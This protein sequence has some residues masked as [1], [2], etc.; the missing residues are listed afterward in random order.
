MCD[1]KGKCERYSNNISIG[2]LNYKMGNSVGYNLIGV[3][4][5]AAVSLLSL[6]LLF[7]V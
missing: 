2:F 4:V 5:Q 3:I 6:I 1:V 7:V